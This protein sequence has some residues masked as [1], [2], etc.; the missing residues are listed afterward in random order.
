M[1]AKLYISIPCS[2][3]Y[4]GTIKAVSVDVNENDAEKIKNLFCE[5]ERVKSISYDEQVFTETTIPR[6]TILR[7]IE[8]RD[9]QVE[10]K[11]TTKISRF[12]KIFSFC[13]KNKSLGIASTVV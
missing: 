9:Q 3:G 6:G 11:K 7:L 5:I 4:Y 12:F 10:D 2:Q 1:S 13:K 8:P